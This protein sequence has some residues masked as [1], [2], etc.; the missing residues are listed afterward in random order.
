MLEARRYLLYIKPVSFNQGANMLTQLSIRNLAVASEIDLEFSEGMTAL[1]GETGAGKSIILDAL[2]LVLGDR[3][4]AEIVRHNC[5]RA[6]INAIFDLRKL[7]QAIHWLHQ[8]DLEQNAECIIRRTVTAEGRSRSYL[9]GQLVSLQDLREFSELLMDIHSQH[10]HQSLLKTG[11]QQQLV[12]DFGNLQQQLD[13]VSRCFQDWQQKTKQ[14]QSL[15]SRTEEV[16]ARVQLLT[17]QVDELDRLALSEGELE[18]L[19]CEQ[20]QLANA[21][22]IL[23]TL[24]EISEGIL[25]CEGGCLGQLRRCIHL[26]EDN[27]DAM[28]AMKSARDMLLEALIQIEEANSDLR[29]AQDV[30]ELDPVRLQE[31]EMRLGTV[32]ELA[33][34]HRV[35]G[36]ALTARQAELREELS[37]LTSADNNAEALQKQV[38][39]MRHHYDQA[40]IRLSKAR[41]HTAAKLQ[42]S[43]Q[44]QLRKLDMSPTFII[45]V[46]P[47]SKPSSKGMEEIEMLISMNPGQPPKPLRKIASGGELSRISLAIQV[48]TAV[49]SQTPTLV[50]DEIDVGIGGPTAEIVGRLLRELGSKTQVL[51]V[52]HLPQVASQAHHHLFVSKSVQE[53][54]TQSKIHALSGDNRTQEIAR[55]LGGI[56]IT[57]HSLAHAKEMLTSKPLH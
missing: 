45:D 3:S 5:K 21:D 35:T 22:K 26:L 2:S 15:H 16:E 54:I 11:I 20:Q 57:E 46:K 29:T 14:L 56:E 42:K 28:P 17:Y 50:F 49:S 52:T 53:G 25:D 41:T 30:V 1:S 12:D 55:M 6:E 39:L 8:R 19:E 23:N 34:K 13:I 43:V 47:L 9:N 51:C 33:R 7:P 27:T 36:Y 40:A 10:E 32:H 31:V 38:E 37:Q 44:Q 4:S 18:Q 24:Q 48:I